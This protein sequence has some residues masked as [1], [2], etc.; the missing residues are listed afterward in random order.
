M[1]Q[2]LIGV[3]GLGYLGIETIRQSREPGE[4]WGSSHQLRKIKTSDDKGISLYHFEWENQDT[5]F[6]FPDSIIKTLLTIPPQLNDSEKETERIATWCSWMKKNRPLCTEMVYVSSTGVYPKQAGLW[7]EECIFEP[8]QPKGRLRWA[9]EKVLRDFF[10]LRVIRPGGIYGPDRLIGRHMDKNKIAEGHL[11][12]RIHVSDLARI[13]LLAL[14]DKKFPLVVNA[15]DLKPCATREVLRWMLEQKELNK[16]PRL[17][18]LYLTWLPE[19]ME[20]KEPNNRKISN[21]CLVED[22]A[23]PFLYPS[24]KEGMKQA[25]MSSSQGR[26]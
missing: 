14:K 15:V 7:G 26:I 23:F 17:R 21:R 3:L 24:Y 11:V 25:L 8:D 9:T 10:S 18:E 6:N 2:P 16:F 1:I 13:A 19:D 5:W 4:F 12:H 22:L 20:E